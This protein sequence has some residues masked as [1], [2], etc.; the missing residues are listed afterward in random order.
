MSIKRLTNPNAQT[1]GG[2]LAE[3]W[4]DTGGIETRGSSTGKTPDDPGPETP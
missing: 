4:C 2:I 3:G 1:P